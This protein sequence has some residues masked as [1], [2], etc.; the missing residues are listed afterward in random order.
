M[1]A[2]LIVRAKVDESCKIQFDKWYENEHLPEALE[3]FSALTAKRGWSNV[4]PNVHI[5]FYEFQN[6]E[7]AEAIISSDT[8]KAFVQEFDRNWLGKVERTRE[9]IGF[10]QKI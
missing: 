2:Y 8:M 9:L 4:E 7:A 10:V 1:T 6:L 5:A 3:A